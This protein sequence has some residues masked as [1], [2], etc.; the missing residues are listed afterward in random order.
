MINH[1]PSESGGKA[2]HSTTH[3]KL[4]GSAV[5]LFRKLRTVHEEAAASDSPQMHKDVISLSKKAV[6]N[7][8]VMLETSRRAP[9]LLT[10]INT[11]RS[12]STLKSFCLNI[13]KLPQEFLAPPK[14]EELTAAQRGTIWITTFM[15]DRKYDECILE[16][17]V[18]CSV[19]WLDRLREC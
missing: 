6:S 5:D 11:S 3:R 12:A 15:K 8:I 16:L 2:I 4:F 14:D 13:L 17:C 7:Y 18:H 1:Y 10:L 19:L 9:Q